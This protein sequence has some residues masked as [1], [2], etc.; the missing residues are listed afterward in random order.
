M[1]IER[2][3]TTSRDVDVVKGLVAGIVGGLVA[4]VVM[5]QFQKILGR[6]ITGEERSHGAQSLQTGAPH[7]GAGRMLEEQG[8]EASDDDSAERLASTISVGLFDHELTESEKDTA[9][10]AFHYAYGISMGAFYG[11][12]SEILPETTFG[13]GMAYGTLIWI[14]ADEVVVPLLGLSK[15]SAEYPFSVH[16]S[17]FASHLVYGLTTETVRRAVRNVM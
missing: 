9:G 13:A 11:A 5:N 4:S 10:T 17:A 6:M 14:G 7:H 1:K 3:A 8:K 12:A 15:S 16:A 2:E